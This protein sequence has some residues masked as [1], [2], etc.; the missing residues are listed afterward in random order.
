MLYNIT[1]TKVSDKTFVRFIINVGDEDFLNTNQHA[2]LDKF[3]CDYVKNFNINK[4]LHSIGIIKETKYLK[5]F[6]SGVIDEELAEAPFHEYATYIFENGKFKYKIIYKE[7][8]KET[9]SFDIVCMKTC[10][11][12]ATQK[13]LL[14]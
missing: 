4:N 1:N 3:I 9:L 12:D 5:S 7:D 13:R 2:E 11:D 6:N 14:K 10:L 8:F